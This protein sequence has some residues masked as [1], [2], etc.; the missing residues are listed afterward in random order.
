LDKPNQKEFTT[1]NTP[2]QSFF[3]TGQAEITEKDKKN[4]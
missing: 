2:I 1:E 4:I 3:L